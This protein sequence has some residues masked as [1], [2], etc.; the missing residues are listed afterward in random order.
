MCEKRIQY[1][2]YIIIIFEAFNVYI[3]IDLVK[4]GVLTLETGAIE[5]TVIIII[6]IIIKISHY[7][8]SVIMSDNYVVPVSRS[9]VNWITQCRH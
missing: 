6:I 2:D 9:R 8:D 1:Y 5:M 7:T 4:R 3:F